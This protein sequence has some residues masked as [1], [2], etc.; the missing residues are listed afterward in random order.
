MSLLRA[1]IPGFQHG[2]KTCDTI[3]RAGVWCSHSQ[4]KG[5]LHCL[6]FRHIPNNYDMLHKIC[7]VT[8]QQESLPLSV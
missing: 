5:R 8:F 2:A 7:I 6:D 1:I 3:W 4:M